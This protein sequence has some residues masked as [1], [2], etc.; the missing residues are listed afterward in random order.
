MILVTGPRGFVGRRI[1]ERFPDAAA[2][3]SELSRSADAEGIAAHVEQVHPSAIFHT[4][5]IS[6]EANADKW[7]DEIAKRTIG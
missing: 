4:A 1:M 5:A 7:S 2:L 6:F 3:P